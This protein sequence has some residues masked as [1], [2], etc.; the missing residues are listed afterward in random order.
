MERRVRG[1]W[2]RGRLGAERGGSRLQLRGYAL[3]ADREQTRKHL[4]RI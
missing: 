4:R 2:D 3:L 1:E